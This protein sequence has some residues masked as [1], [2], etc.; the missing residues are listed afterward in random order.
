MS[1]NAQLA[2]RLIAANRV[3]IDLDAIDEFRNLS[4]SAM[5]TIREAQR[6]LAELREQSTED[7][8]LSLRRALQ[9]VID[10]LEARL[11]FLGRSA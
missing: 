6:V 8:T 2:A 11:H 10:R 4:L 9:D 7:L 5:I 3:L 1:G